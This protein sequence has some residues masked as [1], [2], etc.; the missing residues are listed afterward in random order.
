MG[1]GTILIVEADDQ[2]AE[3]IGEGIRR[4]GFASVRCPGPGA[5]RCPVAESKRCDLV[6]GA[7]A[8]VLDPATRAE[9]GT[10]QDVSPVDLLS[11]YLGEGKPVVALTHSP[12][13]IRPFLDDRVVVLPRPVATNDLVR[14]LKG[15]IL[16]RGSGS[17]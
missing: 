8:I 5:C 2:E 15:L 6:E 14:A 3:R 1:Q 7:D 12:E 11:Y 17:A 16:P 13:R 9:S 10:D 4:A